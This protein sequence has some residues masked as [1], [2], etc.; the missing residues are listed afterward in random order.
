MKKLL[1]TK[2][3]GPQA[4]ER[5]RGIRADELDR[6]HRSLFDKAMKKESVEI[7]KEATKL[8]INS[9]CRMSMGRSFT[10]ESGEAERVR[11]MVTELDGLTKKVL[12]A[13]IFRW[14]LEKLGISLVKKE[15]VFVSNSFDELLE[16]I[17]VEHEEKP[18]KHQGSDL[19]DVLLEVYGDKNA[20]HKITRKDIKSLFVVILCSSH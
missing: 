6:F 8:S 5:S 12:L 10:E 7:G 4:L 11:G 19:M 15:I 1:V 20:E 18:D 13:N 9:I 3:F 2:L 17:L 14:P 16:R